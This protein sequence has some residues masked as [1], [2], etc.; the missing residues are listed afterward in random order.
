MKKGHISNAPTK[1]SGYEAQ[2]LPQ[3]E[4]RALYPGSLQKIKEEILHFSSSFLT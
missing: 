1:A 2:Q 3:W 4:P